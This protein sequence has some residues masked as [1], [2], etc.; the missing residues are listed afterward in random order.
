[1]R[2]SSTQADESVVL[3][4]ASAGTAVAGQADGAVL[5]PGVPRIGR[6]TLPRVRTD[7]GPRGARAALAVMILGVAAVALFATSRAGPLVPRSD[8][9]YPGW[10]S[11]PLHNLLGHLPNNWHALNWGLSGVLLAMVLAYGIVLGSIRS[12]SMRALVLCILALHLILFLNPPF[13]LTDVFNYLGYARLGAVH[14]L[15]P[16][17]HGINWESHDPVFRFSSWHNL[18]SPYGPLFTAISYPVALLPIPV[19]YWIVKLLAVGLSLVFIA[20]VWKCARL[21]G[22]DPRFAVAFVALNPV[23]VMYAVGG[24]HNDFFMLVPST[25][26]IALLLARRDRAAG[27]A[28]MV[29]VAVKFTAVLLLPFLLIAARPPHRRPRVLIGAVLAAI[30]LAVMSVALFGLTIPNLQDQSTLL[31]DFSVPNVVGDLLG[32]GGGTPALLRVANVALAATVILLLRRRRSDWIADAGWSTLALVISLAWL[33]PWYVIWVL[34]LAALGSSVRL[35]RATVAFSVYLVLAFFPLASMT[36]N[37]IGI[38]LMGGPAGHASKVR[39][40][41]LAQ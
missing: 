23:Y 7:F 40:I 2:Q 38:N 33:V 36:L 10:E 14:H 30:P 1:M 41:K 5:V 28:L 20:L 29:A 26:A 24:F 25:A 12:L 6:F 37:T 18:K 8:L 17:T 27:A 39:Q 34:P 21:L 9:G 35:R 19:A 3:A 32:I 16:Y 15:N 22:R 31:T 11:G 13:Q 4:S